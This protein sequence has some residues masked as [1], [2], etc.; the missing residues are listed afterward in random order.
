MNIIK[1]INKDLVKQIAIIKTDIPKI[2]LATDS[3]YKTDDYRQST[4]NHIFDI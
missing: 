3:K 2:I 4:Y 1:Q